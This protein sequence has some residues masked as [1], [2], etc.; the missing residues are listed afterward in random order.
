MSVVAG[1]SVPRTGPAGGPPTPRVRVRRHPERGRY[2]RATVEAVLDAAL[3]GHVGYV[4]DGQPFVT[5]TAIWRTGDRLYWHGSRASRMLRATAERGAVCVTATLVDGLVLARSSF[6]HSLNYR[7]V[8][9]LGQAHEVTGAQE[10]LDALAAFVEHLYPGRWS[11]LRPL[12]RQELRATTI[13]WVDLAEASVKCRAG[14]T[15]EDA[16]DLD[17]P[18]W[19]GHIPIRQ[20]VEG[21]IPDDHLRDGLAPPALAAWLRGDASGSG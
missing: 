4:V 18:V 12:T 6:N 5:P 17:W 2:D 21:P 9:V 11:T 14:G 13:L 1:G 8:M 16:G 3:V 7:S 19:A 20:I 15:K 10:R